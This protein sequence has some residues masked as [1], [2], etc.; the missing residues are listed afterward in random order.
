MPSL[1]HAV[2]DHDGDAAR[3][4]EFDEWREDLLGGS[5]VAGDRPTG[6][7]TDERPHRGGSELGRGFD[8]ARDM[9]V[10]GPPLVGVGM[11]VVPV[12]R[13]RRDA[14]PVVVQAAPH[15]RHFAGGERVDHDV[16]GG[17]GSRVGAGPGRDF[18]RLEPGRRRERSDLLERVAGKAHG[19]EPE[20][21][22]PTST[23]APPE[24]A[25]CSAI[26]TRCTERRPSEKVGSP[27]GG[28]PAIAA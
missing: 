17:E 10:R 27:S 22:V 28:V 14:Q 23:H 7:P 1:H 18:Q 21:H 19:E 6:I 4:C 26:S 25:D 11:E 15:A 20:L 8:A 2:L 9:V 12:V 24:P 13:E 3:A 16:G 5:Q